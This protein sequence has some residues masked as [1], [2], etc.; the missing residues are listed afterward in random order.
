M[1]HSSESLALHAYIC[2]RIMRSLF[3]HI[4]D[5]LT[6]IDFGCGD[7]QLTALVGNA[8]FNAQL[9]GIDTDVAALSYNRIQ[10]PHITFLSPE[11]LRDT[12][13]HADLIYMVNVL[14][15]INPQE[16]KALIPFLLAA[17]KPSGTLVI[18]EL[19]PFIYTIRKLFNK[20][21]YT[22]DPL[23]PSFFKKAAPLHNVTINYLY[24]NHLILEPYMHTIP[25]GSLYMICIK[26]I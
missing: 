12:K 8:F 19:N 13:V 23:W 20:S 22:C 3:H 9:L 10:Y 1:T 24:P 7:A 5:P 11:Q 25:L 4:A 18:F 6:I 16:R 17:L 21:A 14:H 26:N 15:H 2:D